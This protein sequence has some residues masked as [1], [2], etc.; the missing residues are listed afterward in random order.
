MSQELKPIEQLKAA[1]PELEA[2]MQLNA[3]VGIDVKTLVLLEFEYLRMHAL[4]K[5]E[6]MECIPQTIIMCMKSVMKKNLS[7]DPAEGL[8]YVKTR[9]VKVK[10]PQGQ[11][12][13]RKALEIIESAN[14]LISIYRQCG[15]ILDIKNPIVAKDA[16]G[17]VIEVSVEILLPSIPSP[18]WETRSFDES[19]FRRWQIASHK[20]N[21]RYKSDASTEALNYSNPN[22]TSWKGGIDPEFARAKAIRHGLKKLGRNQNEGKFTKIQISDFAKEVIIDPEKDQAGAEEQF[23]P[24]ED[25]SSNINSQAVQPNNNFSSEAI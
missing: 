12:Q 25:I 22:Y 13:T 6:I 9:N 7:L 23:T 20:E 2:I 24:H 10:D 15:R 14:G 16:D 5:P 8:V 19:D 1:A 11:E 3:D 4:H 18:R 17:K 21:G